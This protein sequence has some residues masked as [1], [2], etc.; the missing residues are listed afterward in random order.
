MTYG[1]GYGLSSTTFDFDLQG[2]PKFEISTDP[3][4]GTPSAYATFS[5]KVTNTGS[6]AGKTPVQIYGQAP[7]TQGGV[8]KPAIQLLNFEKSGVLAPGASETVEVKVDLQFI[9]S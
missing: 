6:A 1:F 7:Y 5:V 4:T 3:E 9:A 8:E 2:E